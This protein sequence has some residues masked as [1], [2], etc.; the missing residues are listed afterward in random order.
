[1][2]CSE[3]AFY[4]LA[5]DSVVPYLQKDV[6]ILLF[7]GNPYLAGMTMAQCIGDSF[8]DNPVYGIFLVLVKFH[9]LANLQHFHTH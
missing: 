8:L 5:S 2:L 7:Y 9:K 3:S 4:L 6:R 1:M